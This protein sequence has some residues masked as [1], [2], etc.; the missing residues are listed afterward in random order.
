MIGMSEMSQEPTRGEEKNSHG[1]WQWGVECQST[2]STG[3]RN[4]FEKLR[5]SPRVNAMRIEMCL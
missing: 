5:A 1:T 2:M 3:T 4:D